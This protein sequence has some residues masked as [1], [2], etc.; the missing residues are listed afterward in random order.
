LPDDGQR[1]VSAVRQ[2]NATMGAAWPFEVRVGQHSRNPTAQRLREVGECV[3]KALL[4]K[5]PT[6]F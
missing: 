1:L 3:R 5:P 2:S 4:Q 6:Y